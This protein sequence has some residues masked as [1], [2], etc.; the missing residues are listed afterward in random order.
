MIKNIVRIEKDE[1]ILKRIIYLL[2]YFK[3]KHRSGIVEILVENWGTLSSID[4]RFV[5]HLLTH[6]SI[7]SQILRKKVEN[8][9]IQDFGD[10]QKEKIARKGIEKVL[11]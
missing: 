5:V 8:I 11:K 7:D 10:G 4:Y 1:K 6:Y 2:E 9:L 3:T